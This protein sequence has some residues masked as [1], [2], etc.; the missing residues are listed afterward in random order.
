[1]VLNIKIQP[2][3]KATII[4]LFLLAGQASAQGITRDSL[5]NYT[6]IW[7]GF[8]FPDSSN[9]KPK[10]TARLVW[11]IHHVDTIKNEI[12]IT[13]TGQRFDNA[14][15]IE[16]PKKEIYKM[17]FDSSGFSIALRGGLPNSKY[18]LRLSHSKLQDLKAMKGVF[19]RSDK[20]ETSSL[21]IFAKISDDTSDYVKPIGKVE[22]VVSAPPS[23]K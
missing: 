12:E 13:Q 8:S 15:E 22:V 7:M 14:S 21:F 11:R 5:S 17:Y 19:E 18:K 9:L 3:I 2:Y 1:M 23:I 6:G 10:S 16:N 4:A 20:K